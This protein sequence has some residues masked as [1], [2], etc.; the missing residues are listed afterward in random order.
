MNVLCLMGQ[1][2]LPGPGAPARHSA[3]RRRINTVMQELLY[4][5]VPLIEHGRQLIHGLGANNRVGKA[6]VRVEGELFAADP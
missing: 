3:N 2:G 5:A 1:R 6:F 4:R